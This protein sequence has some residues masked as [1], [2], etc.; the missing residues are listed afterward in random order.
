MVW[1]AQLELMM[2]IAVSMHGEFFL[3]FFFFCF[4]VCVKMALEP[5]VMFTL[6]WA[7]V[8]P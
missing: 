8:S 5:A 7:C 1:T 6:T 3:L 2:F 4:F